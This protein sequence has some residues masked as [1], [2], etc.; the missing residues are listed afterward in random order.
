MLQVSLTDMLY[1][2]VQ[3]QQKIIIKISLQIICGTK[4]TGLLLFK[5]SAKVVALSV[6]SKNFSCLT[7]SFHSYCESSK[8][9]FPIKLLR[10]DPL[11]NKC[12]ETTEEGR[13]GGA[14][15]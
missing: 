5:R 8:P 15:L 14:H 7:H 4:E 2:T 3:Q 13:H 10:L 12:L 1:N 11:I 6:H 9:P